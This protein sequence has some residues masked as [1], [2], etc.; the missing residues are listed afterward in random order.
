MKTA[1][2]I[3][4]PE[5]SSQ[6]ADLYHDMET[7]YDETAKTLNFSCS[8]CPDNCCDSYFQH[9]TYTEW[10]YLWQGLKSL[11]DSQLQTIAA[12]AAQYL[13]ASEKALARGERP[14]IMCALNSDGLCSLYSYRLMICRLHGVPATFTR[15][16]GQ[17]ADFPGCFRCQEQISHHASVVPLDRTQFLRRLA[18]LEIRLLSQRRT[19]PARVKLTIAQMIVKGPPIL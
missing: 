16:D 14:V 15:P 19:P 17:K 8:G 10:A 2:I 4:K 9:H 5:F 12:K 18:E 13:L 11:A 7:A 6:V 3:L 1:E